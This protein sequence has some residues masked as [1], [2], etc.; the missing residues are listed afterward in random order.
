MKRFYV[1]SYNGEVET[2]EDYYARKEAM[3]QLEDDYYS[4]KE[5][6]IRDR[7]I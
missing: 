7:E 2:L 1:P 3:E 5:D 6:K 4:E